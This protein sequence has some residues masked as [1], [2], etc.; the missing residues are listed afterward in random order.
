MKRWTFFLFV[1]IFTGYAFAQE[2]DTTVPISDY[3]N[4]EIDILKCPLDLS[5]K[6]LNDHTVSLRWKSSN[7]KF[8]GFNLF[9]KSGDDKFIEIIKLDKS[10]TFFVDEN[11]KFNVIY[12]Y[13]VQCYNEEIKSD[14]SDEITISTVFPMPSNLDAK[15]IDDQSV[16]ITWQDN[17]DFETGFIIER[18]S[19]DTQYMMAGKV[20]ADETVYIDEGLMI[21]EKYYYQIKAESE[22]NESL[23]SDKI[24]VETEFPAPANFKVKALDDQSVRLTWEDG[25]D[26]ENGFII[27]RKTGNEEFKEIATVEA[28]SRYYIDEEL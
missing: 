3:I 8:I 10:K 28:N 17:C 22:I 12:S 1:L 19:M 16:M 20:S 15:P 9:R 2:I 7:D 25:Y 4:V 27:E 11:L 21:G 26:Y 13:K 5:A 18:K 24:T 6:A 23:A 14:F